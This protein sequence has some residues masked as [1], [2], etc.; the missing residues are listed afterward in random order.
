VRD[1]ALR[2]D[3]RRPAI[4][5]RGYGGRLR[6]PLRVD[7]ALH[8][9]E[10][11]GD[12]P[13]M[14]APAAPCWIGADRA[15]AARAIA[16]SGA[17]LIIMDDGLQNADLRQDLRLIVVDGAAGFGNRRAIPA[18]P[19]RETVAAGIARA[20]ALIVMGPDVHDLT[21]AFSGRL[22]VL[23]AEVRLTEERLL[24]GQ[25]VF[26]F[27]GIGRPAKFRRT[28][29]QA[30]AEIAAFH[31]FPDHHAYTDAELHRLVAEAKAAG[32]APITTEKDWMRLS[33]Y[34]KDHI[35]PMLASLVWKDESE[36]TRL[37]EKV[38][39]IG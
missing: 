5:S 35:R 24:A 21:R 25:R 16:A 14:L 11:V 8:R 28:L 22:P 31:G 26:A 9:A 36:I 27:A 4:L 39:E 19:L 13:L 29:E 34:W 20:D 7:P 23:H 1:L 38:S 32:T 2:L 15:Q 3:A 18:G 10:D 17:G 33:P 30:G 6:G 12:E 37:L